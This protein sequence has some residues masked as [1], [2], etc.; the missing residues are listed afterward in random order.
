LDSDAEKLFR[1]LKGIETVQELE[2]FSDI[3]DLLSECLNAEEERLDQWRTHLVETVFLIS[4]YF[5]DVRFLEGIQ[6]QKDTF[7][8][9]INMFNKLNQMPEKGENLLI[10]Y[11]GQPT[12]TKIS[13]KIDYV[14]YCGK[15]I[16]DS[17]I[18]QAMLNRMGLR[19]AHLTG[20]LSSAFEVFSKQGIN[21]LFMQMPGKSHSV[22]E[23]LKE[24]L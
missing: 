11:R 20:R 13:P 18:V 8:Q 19:M 1:E 2:K 4:S 3:A 7:S 21:T 12:G 17:A 14:V 10:Q 24:C 9:L 22:M 5:V 23:Q 6:D 15:L 16:I